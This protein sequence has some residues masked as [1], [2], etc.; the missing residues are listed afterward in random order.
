MAFTQRF[1]LIKPDVLLPP[2]WGCAEC[3]AT[4]S[5]DP[6][7]SGESPAESVIIRHTDD[8]RYSLQV[9]GNPA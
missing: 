5:E 3:K 8:C 4:M 9:A 6:E 2:E 1:E 7:P